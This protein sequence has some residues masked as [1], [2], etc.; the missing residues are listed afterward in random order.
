M[1]TGQNDLMMVEDTF[2]VLQKLVHACLDHDCSEVIVFLPFTYDDGGSSNNHASLCQKLNKYCSDVASSPLI[3]MDCVSIV[4]AKHVFA[5]DYLI[6]V[7]NNKHL[8]LAHEMCFHHIHAKNF[9]NIS[10]TQIADHIAGMMNIMPPCNSRKRQVDVISKNVSV[11]KRCCQQLQ[12]TIS[13]LKDEGDRIEKTRLVEADA[14]FNTMRR[15]DDSLRS[16]SDE[17]ERLQ[18]DLQKE[19]ARLYRYQQLSTEYA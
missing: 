16:N 13:G 11:I 3:G 6:C 7:P 15:L 5:E 8:I 14:F 10:V 1:F 18:N 4:T 19:K 17:R 9:S 12:D 2:L